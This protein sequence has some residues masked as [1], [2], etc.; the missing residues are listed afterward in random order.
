MQQEHTYRCIITLPRPATTLLMPGL[1]HHR[2]VSTVLP[3]DIQARVGMKGRAAQN[4][5]KTNVGT[6]DEDSS[7][8]EC[9]TLCH[10]HSM[11][12]VKD[13]LLDMEAQGII[14]PAEDNLSAWCHP[15]VIIPKSNDDVHIVITQPCWKIRYFTPPI[16]HLLCSR[17]VTLYS[18]F[19]TITIIDTGSLSLWR[20]TNIWHHLS[21]YIKNTGIILVQWCSQPLKAS[22]VSIVLQKCQSH[23]TTLNTEKSTL[24]TSSVR[25]CRFVLSADGITVEVEESASLNGLCYFIQHYWHGTH[26]PTICTGSWKC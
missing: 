9:A 22:S 14:V 4:T 24:A 26:Q 1:L 13:E 21:H 2:P 12:D 18:K 10:Q 20:K 3:E 25:Y 23:G 7:Y 11:A 16:P 6:D 19:F 5:C 8:E 15:L 17:S